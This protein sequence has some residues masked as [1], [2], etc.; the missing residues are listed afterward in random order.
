MRD[1]EYEERPVQIGSGDT[2]CFF[3]DGVT[4]TENERGELFGTDRLVRLVKANKDQSARQIRER[5]VTEV[6]SFRALDSHPDD[7]TLILI[8][9]L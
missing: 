2:L 9:A 8:K 1:R 3:T 5:I 7:L 4:E 6:E